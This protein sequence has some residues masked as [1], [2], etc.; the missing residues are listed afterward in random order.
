[1]VEPDGSLE[2]DNDGDEGLEFVSPP[3]PIDELL[4]DLNAVKAWAGRMGVY[5]NQSTGLHINISVPEY[6]KDRLDFVKLALLLGDEYVLDLFGRASNTYA[7]SALG[8]VRDRVRQRPEEAQQLLDKMKGQM[9]ELASKAIHGG[10][11]D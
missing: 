2:G 9:G 5:T 1:V 3:M 8:K 11:T 10:Y 7:K 4:K 6:S